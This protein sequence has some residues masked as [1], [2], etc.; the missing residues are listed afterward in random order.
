MLS[1]EKPI[2]RVHA[3]P[4]VGLLRPPCLDVILCDMM[5][6]LMSGDRFFRA[7]FASFLTQETTDFLETVDHPVVSKPLDSQ[8][9]RG[10]MAQFSLSQRD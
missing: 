5:M 6:P 1:N 10:L 9:L 2:P 3:S 8:E 4:L 7:L